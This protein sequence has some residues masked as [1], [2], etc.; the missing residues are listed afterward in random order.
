MS[1][2]KKLSTKASFIDLADQLITKFKGCKAAGASTLILTVFGDSICPQGGSVWL[3]CLI[4]LVEPLGINQRLVRTSVFRL[5]QNGQLE[6][7]QIGR[8]SYYSLSETALR[9]CLSADKR[10]YM[11]SKPEWDG[12]WRIVFTSLSDITQEQ[13]DSIQKELTWLGFGV[14]SPGVYGHPTMKVEPVQCIIDE[15]G[16]NQKVTLMLGRSCNPE[17]EVNSNFF[18][19]YFDI[20]MIAIK[21]QKFIDTF[22]PLLEAAKETPELDPQMCFLIRTLLIN[23]FRHILNLEPEFPFELLPD[24]FIGHQSRELTRSLYRILSTQSTEHLNAVCNSVGESLA[25]MQASYFER[26]TED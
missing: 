16:L 2:I 18:K 13:R 24:D 7:K 8:R 22:M 10:I 23:E 19:P 17:N 26:L 3:G 9:Q 12:K 20:E 11:N 14:I 5:S 6:S 21:H 1:T 4:K 15:L 25:P